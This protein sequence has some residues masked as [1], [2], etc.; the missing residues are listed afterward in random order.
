MVT[1]SR[2]LGRY[3]RNTHHLR[4]TVAFVR[5]RPL[6]ASLSSTNRWA[7]TSVAKDEEQEKPKTSAFKDA[8]PVRI[9]KSL[10]RHIWPSDDS[11][12][13]NLRK[14]RVVAS[15]GLML[16]GKAVTIQVPYIF[17]HLVD[18]LPVDTANAA[19]TA[20]AVSSA[21]V[22]VLALLLGYGMSR[23]ASSGFN[24]FRNAVFA[25]VAQ[26]TIRK[27]GRNVFDHVHT[28]DLQFHLNKN[29]GQVS[30]ILD[31]SNRS[32][33]FVL[34]ALVF[35]I[36]PT[37]FEV[38]LVTALVGYQFGPAHGGVILA[39]IGGYTVF[40]VGITQWRTKFRRDMNRLENQVQYENYMHKLHICL[41][42]IAH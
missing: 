28:L 2:I 20:D 25:R 33:S 17:K 29:T 22:P 16:A 40:T 31:R 15:L 35:N 26:E 5:P 6:L 4:R 42:L 37:V 9:A 21:G 34:N 38:G 10:S 19:M 1:S 24:E 41:F 39:T 32:I 11:A 8:A 7:T 36:L 12:E 3:L 14:K 27:V 30:R 18:S 13:S 23:A